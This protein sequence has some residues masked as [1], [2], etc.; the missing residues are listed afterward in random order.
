MQN[1]VMCVCQKNF[2]QKKDFFFFFMMGESKG[3]V[4]EIVKI[5][6]VKIKIVSML[7]G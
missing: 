6:V 1:R 3:M 2:E 5:G 7:C 4:K